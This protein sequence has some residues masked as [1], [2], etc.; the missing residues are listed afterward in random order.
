MNSPVKPVISLAREQEICELADHI[1]ESYQTSAGTNLAGILKDKG[2][3]LFYEQFEESFDGLIDLTEDIPYIYCNLSTG[4]DPEG[5]RT[6]FTI[7]HELGHFFI[8]EHRNA[9]ASGYMPS[10]GE[11]TT[12]DLIIEREADLFASRLLM[13]GKTYL[14]Q[15]KKVEPGLKGVLALSKRFNV[16]LKCAAIRYLSEDICSCALS[17]WSWEGKLVWKWFSK[18]MWNAGIRKFQPTPVAK[19]AVDLCL[20][21]SEIPGYND[22]TYGPVSYLFQSIAHADEIVQDEAIVLGEYGVLS[23]TRVQNGKLKPLADV[24]AERYER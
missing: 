16:S 22:N 23:L 1:G 5:K 6:R 8:D 18:S 13:P 17:F 15:V 2:I 3:E 20:K 14:K 19:G 7:S 10:L 24:L 12:K 9:L 21:N 11:Y 4:N